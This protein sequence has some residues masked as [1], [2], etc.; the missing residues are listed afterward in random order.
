[1]LTISRKLLLLPSL[2]LLSVV[3]LCQ[4]VHET[5]PATQTPEEYLHSLVGQK[6]IMLQ[7]GDTY[8]AKVKK[9]DLP[10]I[11][12]SCDIAVQIKMVHQD[13]DKID[14]AWEQIGTP[15]IWGKNFARTCRD[16]N[17]HDRGILTITGF[18]PDETTDSLTTSLSKVLQTPEQ[19]LATAGIMFNLPAE[20]DL[21][22]IPREPPAMEPPKPLL[23]FDPAFSVEAR[24]RK[25]Q[26]RVVVMFYVGTDGRAHRPSI[27]RP[28]GMGL[29]QQVLNVLPL[30][31]FQPG[32]KGGKP[33]VAHLN[34]EI[35][36]NLY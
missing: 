6:L 12:I 23:S 16:N 17:Y 31:R 35:S 22:S 24:K 10:K 27:P 8:R 15:S 1:M 33:V 36:F 34:M 3:A 9:S 29:D 14:F 7:F 25:Y 11:K 26:G 32:S 5:T 4:S 18:A 21:Q 19:Y 30:C 28:L 2:L 20:P 13:K